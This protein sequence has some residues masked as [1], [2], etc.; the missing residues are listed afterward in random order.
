[1]RIIHV[2]SYRNGF[3]NGIKSVLEELV[4]AQRKLG[5]EVC[6]LNHIQTEHKEIEGELFVSG[7][8]DF[9]KFVNSFHPDVV[10]F[11][12]LYGIADVRFSYYL[13]KRRIPYLVEPHGGTSKENA[14]KNSFKKHIANIIYANRFLHNANG[15][16]YL[17]E[18]EKEECVFK[19][20]RKNY[21]I[22]PNGTRIHGLDGK[23]R[24]VEVVSFVFLARIDI[25]QKGLDYLFPAIEEANKKGAYNKAEFHFYGKARNPQWGKMFDDY[26]AK[27]CS[28]VTYH[29]PAIGSAKEKAFQEGDIFILTSRYEGMPMAVLEAMS[30]GLPCLITPQ[31]NVSDIIKD[32]NCGW[33]TNLSVEDI[34]NS[35][36]N[37][38]KDFQGRR[39][40]LMNNALKAAK[41]YDWA[42]IAH[43]SIREYTRLLS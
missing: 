14:K 6:I 22:I 27:A 16:I 34:T 25:L 8:K 24:S 3:F 20:T 10:I 9:I 15:L 7:L 42:S 43:H 33:I 38:I 23:N 26:I 36:I 5:H 19:K 32:N 35:I 1:M 37:V 11:H 31:T 39:N 29:G 40:E 41:L 30:Y 2:A 4:P 13:R 17:N 18:K 21:A 12:S 28:N